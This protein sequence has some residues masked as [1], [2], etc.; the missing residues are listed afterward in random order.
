VIYEEKR[1]LATAK[2]QWLKNI[3]VVFVLQTRKWRRIGLAVAIARCKSHRKC[4][5]T[6]EV[7]AP[8]EEDLGCQAISIDS[9]YMKSLSQDYIIKLVESMPRKCQAIINNRGDLLI[10]KH[11]DLYHVVCV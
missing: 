5:G 4:L 10:I 11:H 1:K 6:H 3:G 2:G 8:R 7:Q 9:T